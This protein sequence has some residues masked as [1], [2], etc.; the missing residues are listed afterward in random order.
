MCVS[1]TVVTTPMVGRAMRASS[2]ISP[3]S[4]VPSSSTR[5]V[6]VSGIERMVSGVPTR[7]LRLACV[8]C[9]RCEPARA[10]RVRS[11][12]VVFPDEPVIATT[13]TGDWRR[14]WSAR[15]PRAFRVSG[16]R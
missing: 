3:G 15:S 2:A 12:T 13:G 1:E 6:A 16:T 7:L 8:A 4:F 11:L 10:P 5:T 14:R 9:A